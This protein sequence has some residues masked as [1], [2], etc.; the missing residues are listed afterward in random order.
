M[1]SFNLFVINIFYLFPLHAIKIESV[2][3]KIIIP[4]ND[5]VFRI[6]FVRDWVG[7]LF[8]FLKYYHVPEIVEITFANHE[9]VGKFT[10]HE[11]IHNGAME[12]TA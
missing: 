3:F 4:D 9:D 10:A 6:V 8:L 5:L 7:E 12:E 2:N 1:N 11:V